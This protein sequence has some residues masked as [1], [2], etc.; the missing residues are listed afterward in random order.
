MGGQVTVVG[1]A[2]SAGDFK[3]YRLSIGAGAAPESFS[4]VRRSTAAVANGPLGVV[5]AGSLPSGSLQT[6]RLEAEDV[7]GNHTEARVT[8]EVDNTPPAAPVLLTAEL[9]G[10]S[11]SLTWEAMPGAEVAG[12][13]LFRNGVLANAPESFAELAPYVLPPDRTEYLDSDLPDG[14]FTYELQALDA[15]GNIGPLS[16][17]LTV[18]IDRRAPS[19]LIAT[20]GHLARIVGA[21][22]VAAEV[23]DQDVV[24]VLFEARGA[25]EVGFTPVGAP[26]TTPPYTMEL[27]PDLLASRVIELR[28]VAT[29]RT[30]NTD[31]SPPSVWVFHEPPINAPAVSTLVDGWDVTAG[32][33]RGSASDQLA[34]FVLERD[35]ERLGAGEGRPHGIA[36][37]SATL[38]GS[39]DLAYD[40]LGA[41]VWAAPASVP[42]TWTLD[43][44]GP[45]VLEGLDAVMPLTATAN[46]QALVGGEWIEVVSNVTP[47]PHMGLRVDVSPPLEVGGVR[48]VFT[49]APAGSIQLSEVTLRTTPLMD[50]TEYVEA[51]PLGDHEYVVTAFGRFGG[52]ARAAASAKVSQ[53]ALD[54]V[55]AVVA[56]SPITVTGAMALAGST[57]TF[58]RDGSPIST[59]QAD[60]EGRFSAVVPL[61]SDENLIVAVASDAAGNRSVPSDA[62]QVFLDAPPQVA[63]ALTLDGVTGPDVALSF[64]VA[65]DSTNVDHFEARRSTGDSVPTVTILDAGVRTFVDAGVAN[66]TFTYVVVPVTAHGLVGAPSNAVTAVVAQPA[67]AAPTAVAVAAPPAGGELAVSW[68]GVPG[69]AGYQLQ[70]ATSEVGPFATVAGYVDGTGWVD[71]NLPN[72]VRYC[73]RISSVDSVGNRSEPSAV[74]CGIARDLVPPEPPVIQGPTVAGAPISVTDSLVTVSG[75]ARDGAFVDVYRN[76]RLAGS[77]PVTGMAL[78]VTPFD[79]TGPSTGRSD[80]GLSAN[81]DVVAY[82][83]ASPTNR[84]SLAIENRVSGTV[85]QVERDDIEFLSPPAVSP[86]GRW[87]VL[88]GGA[89]EAQWPPSLYLVDASSG[90]VRPLVSGEARGEGGATFAADSR[91]V[92][93]WAYRDAGSACVAWMD[94]DEGVE[95]VAYEDPG[96][97]V[98]STTWLAGNALAAVLMPMEEG[99]E[100]VLSRIELETGARS[101]LAS[102]WEFAYPVAASLRGDRVAFV[103]YD[104]NYVGAVQVVDVAT[105]VS[106]QFGD[107]PWGGPTVA[108]SP[109]GAR[110]AWSE[111]ASVVM[112]DVA[113]GVTET[114]LEYSATQNIWNAGGTLLSARWASANFLDW[115]AQ[116]EV[117]G[118]ALEAGENLLV[119]VAR[120]DGGMSEPSLPI[121]VALEAA[122]PDLAVTGGI[123]PTVVASG[124]QATAYLRIANAG[125]APIGGCRIGLTL[126]GSDAGQ[127]ELPAVAISTGIAAGGSVVV[128]VAFEAPTVSGA[129]QL[130][131]SVEPDAGVVEV[132]RENNQ[133]TLGFT[134]AASGQLALEASLDRTS[135]L[136]GDAGL[137][138]VR[139]VNPGSAVELV[140][141][142]AVED[143]AGVRAAAIGQDAILSPMAGASETS[144]TRVFGASGL[145]AGPYVVAV[146]ALAG[147]AVVA[148]RA[149]PIAV[150]ADRQVGLTLQASR[151]R[152]LEG[153]TPEVT[154]RVTNHSSNA[155][156]TGAGYRVEIRDAQGSLVRDVTGQLGPMAPGAAIT[157]GSAF[158][159]LAAG[160][161]SVGGRVLLGDAVVASSSC[162]F[163]VS[164]RPLLLGDIQ[165]SGGSGTPMAVPMGTELRVAYSVT[166]AGSAA[167]EQAI[168]R[169]L[170]LDGP[171]DAPSW[172]IDAPLG[173]LSPGESFTGEVTVPTVGLAY[174]LHEV[175]LG[176]T[177][178]SGALTGLASARF[179]VA[180]GKPPTLSVANV[181]AGLFVRSSFD[182]A[183]DA[184]D[185]VAGTSAVRATV[186]DGA[187]VSL[188]LTSGTAFGGRWSGPIVLG[189][190]GPHVIV[191]SGADAEGNDGAS[192][193]AVGNPVALPVIVDSTPPRV[194]IGGVADGAVTQGPV[195][196]DVEAWDLNLASLR[197]LLDGNEVEP[198]SLVEAEGEHLLVASA[199]DWAANHSAAQVRF[200][201]DRTAPSINVS[202]VA[203][204]Q[205]Y[206]GAVNPLI[207]V[208]DRHLA[209][210]VTTLNG[211]D[212]VSGGPISGE[213]AYVLAI[214]AV[215]QAGNESVREIRFSIDRTAPVVT[216]GGFAD[217]DVLVGDV[218][219]TWE[220]KDANLRQVLAT[221]DGVAVVEGVV[222]T[223]EGRHLLAVTATDAAG[224]ETTASGVFTID[225]SAP[226]IVI[227]GFADGQYGRADVAPTVDVT[228]ED[229][230]SA[231]ITLDGATFAPG[232]LVSAEG[233]HLL[234]VTA[235]DRAGNRAERSARFTIDRT[236][237]RIVFSGFME[238]G[239]HGASVSPVVDAEDASLETL[240]VTLDAAPFSSGSSVAA[241]GPHVLVAVAVDRAGN[242]AE[243]IGTFTIDTRPPDVALGGFTDGQ[244]GREVVRPT[245]RVVDANL[246]GTEAWLDD[247][248]FVDGMVVDAS[249]LHVLRVK[250]TDRAG[251][252]TTASAS[253]TIDRTAPEIVVSGVTDG[254]LVNGDVRVGFQ[255]TDDALS[256]VLATLDGTEFASGGTVSAEGLHV[257]RISAED[258]AGNRT[259][260]SV[261]FEID[262]TLPEIAVGGVEDGASYD[263]P[264]APTVTVT[265]AHLAS[266]SVTL[267]GAPFASG[268]A[269]VADGEHVLVARGEDGA[270]NVAELTIRFRI[271]TSLPFKVTKYLAGP[272]LRVLA[273]VSRGGCRLPDSVAARMG[274]LLRRSLGGDGRTVTVVE[275]EPGFLAG[276]RS[277]VFNVHVV[278]S[279][280]AGS[281]P[282]D[283]GHCDEREDDGVERHDEDDGDGDDGGCAGY[284][285]GLRRSTYLELAEAVHAGRAGALLIRTSPASLPELRE[286]VGAELAGMVQAQGVVFQGVLADVAPLS[287]RTAAAAWKVGAAQPIGS[288]TGAPV[289]RRRVAAVSN[290]LGRGRVV[291]LGFDPSLSGSAGAAARLLA[292]AAEWVLPA[293]AAP[294]P[295]GVVGVDVVV[296]NGA[297]ASRLRAMELLEPG[298]EAI[299]AIP[300]TRIEPPGTTF[301]WEFDLAEDATTSLQYLVRLPDAAGVFRTTTEIS[302]VREGGSSVFEDVVLDIVLGENGGDLMAAARAAAAQLATC[303]A[304]SWHAAA[305]RSALERVAGRVTDSRRD[306]AR[307]IDDLLDAVAHVKR[308]ESN[309]AEALRVLLDDLI[310]YW[311]ARWTVEP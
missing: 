115:S 4:V 176:V 94:L 147:G 181:A 90:T 141:R 234:F 252:A 219:P 221:L 35:G 286:L 274:E 153:E 135:F 77:G 199:A 72:G 28:A 104:A 81:G 282:F 112:A 93:Y 225:R 242:R 264:V 166:N 159:G 259:E 128:P 76:G 293:A 172:A 275:D 239:F 180:D 289:T 193:P 160:D 281:A 119:A 118:I 177:A 231:E 288:Y 262:R 184:I 83:Y 136:P 88:E 121:L 220:A 8:L 241:E 202:G 260:R 12:F 165:L 89:S 44:G 244:I 290:V 227:G 25:G 53:P 179:R 144:F 261:S 295:M 36:S 158:E 204:G 294:V 208:A 111:V 311:E 285:P 265:D 217:G 102:S 256:R 11:V 149:L 56:E 138:T 114:L 278:A 167:S 209:S 129:A 131:V 9:D 64:Q 55:P 171:G 124:G 10:A 182:L 116:F 268:T 7:L 233:T 229:L 60:G 34:G 47:D 45:A 96:F 132:G 303:G 32:W 57:V 155:F 287:L 71:A 300:E 248:P 15:A 113:T 207:T 299:L 139:I 203:D 142:A 70:R 2:T 298:L 310:Q 42:I 210:R 120:D 191:V 140:V 230:A 145:V 254:A 59:A 80:F 198:G 178:G 63:I 212:F 26:V 3:E 272:S 123:Q 14:T 98:F 277:G 127:R 250:A 162:A 218:A 266:V 301:A 271:G 24:S 27:D 68:A 23:V 249:G 201:I 48:L 100:M 30:G 1:T 105:G 222:V 19:A 66:G 257:L 245:V 46:L 20:P 21:T 99:A 270:G 226:R 33:Q 52:T 190:D 304:E 305:I 37:A 255:V 95:R 284:R 5:D 151:T 78:S 164:G 267:D 40:Q 186:D 183:V 152:Y 65:G 307:N 291:G 137:L 87:V 74:A 41:T 97:E 107:A 156:L 13:L 122:L 18:S 235:R 174:R 240:E 276:L 236:A 17:A 247:L 143:G 175:I 106:R 258:A 263:A 69:A 306:A 196:P 273:L 246:G 170:I 223:A 205:V 243:R 309:E 39:P 86:D 279:L 206:P 50:V 215:D 161:Y 213:G 126:V 251:N 269:V 85:T 49:S 292:R 51:L 61:A 73:Y 54:G 216:L 187:P 38:W 148:R 194:T 237:P 296:E 133:A 150:L 125:A 92:A 308:I 82:R 109:D 168:A 280:D 75:T 283:E 101:D 84:R 214:R 130:T 154:G 67:L 253:F 297:G 163:S 302:V 224:H 169:L 117:S 185:E 200:T 189:P 173:A 197:T 195:R 238:A 29:D 232:T 91:R 228:D 16:N 134:V 22:W 31:Q 62:A 157:F 146:E 108:L 6:L 192:S 43:L 211:Q 79:A 103:A 58:L 188:A 110:V